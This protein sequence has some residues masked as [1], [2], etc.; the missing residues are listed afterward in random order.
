MQVDGR[1]DQRVT[2]KELGVE[3]SA[4]PTTHPIPNELSGNFVLRIKIAV[5]RPADLRWKNRQITGAR[6]PF[7]TTSFVSR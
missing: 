1:A 3:K 7:T 5:L 4:S 2:E 6:R